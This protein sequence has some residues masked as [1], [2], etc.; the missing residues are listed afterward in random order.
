MKGNYTADLESW[1]ANDN[2]FLNLMDFLIND[3]RTG[4]CIFLSGDVHFAL[5]IKGTLTLI[6]QS[7][8]GALKTIDIAQLTS[9]YSRILLLLMIL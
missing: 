2:G 9:S 5:T 3:L 4:R 7:K 1:N 8:G 6:P